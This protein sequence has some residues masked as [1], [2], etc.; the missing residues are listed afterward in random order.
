MVD[1]NI[2]IWDSAA[3]VLLVEEAG[4]K[5]VC[6]GE[7]LDGADKRY[8]WVFGKPEVVEWVRVAISD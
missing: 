1:Y 2:R 3:S 4:G 7:R 8:D 5:A 6:L